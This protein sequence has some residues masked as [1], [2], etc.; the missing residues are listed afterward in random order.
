MAAR[1]LFMRNRHG[2]PLQ[3]RVFSLKRR[4]DRAE[5]YVSLRGLFAPRVQRHHI[6]KMPHAA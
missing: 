3:V 5:L 1:L 4:A 6:W 2:G